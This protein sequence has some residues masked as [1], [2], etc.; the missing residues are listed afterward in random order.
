MLH[1]LRVTPEEHPVLLTEDPL[2][3][4]ANREKM[5][6]LL[7]EDGIYH[8]QFANQAVLTLYSTGR[9]HGAVLDCGCGSTRVVPICDGY[10]IKDASQV[11]DL[12]GTNLTEHLHKHILDVGCNLEKYVYNHNLTIN[13]VQHIKEKLCYVAQDFDKEMSIAKSSSPTTYT[14]PDGKEIDLGIEQFRCPESLFRPSLLGKEF[15]GG[16]HSILNDSVLK[17][18]AVFQ[19]DL[20]S[21]IVISGGTTLLPGFVERMRKE[22]K[23]LTREECNIN[24]PVERKHS[25]WLGGSILAC[26]CDSQKSMWIAKNEYDEY[27]PYIVHSKCFS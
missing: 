12:A 7:F 17:S 6:E 26:L 3:P 9:I 8:L 15:S 4:K 22:I 20:Y 1:E 10:P 19:K 14:L 25:V 18:D 27:G 2:N 23:C 11:V 21:N 13:L 24:V 5:A 16:I